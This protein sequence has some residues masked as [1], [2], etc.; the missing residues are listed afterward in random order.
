M[1]DSCFRGQR[2]VACKLEY[3]EILVLPFGS[4]VV[5]VM[6]K[7]ESAGAAG[8]DQAAGIGHAAGEVDRGGFDR[9]WPIFREMEL[10]G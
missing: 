9:R 1:L 4:D 10:S 2:L 3:H 8:A 5:H 6:R 7:R